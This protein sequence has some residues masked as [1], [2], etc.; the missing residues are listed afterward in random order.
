MARA[1]APV[2]RR[3]VL[4]AVAGACLLDGGAWAV[5]AGRGDGHTGSAAT[6]TAADPRAVSRAVTTG[7][8]LAITFDDGPDP[9]V[10]PAILDVLAAYDVRATFFMIGRNVRAHPDLARR[11]VAA[12]HAVANHTQ[13]HLWLDGL[14]AA[15]IRDQVVLG[16]RSLR[17][18]VGGPGPLFRPPRGWTSPDVAAVTE[19]LQVRSVF[20]SDCLE[21]HLSAGYA[22]AAR[23]VVDGAEPGSIILCHD[24]GRLDGP[25][26]QRQDRSRTVAALP[27]MLA[28]ILA[29]GLTPALLSD[30]L[31]TG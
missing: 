1:S 21:A 13:D 20:W 4:T 15:G 12:G 31:R 26:P 19:E 8:H 14:P 29:K 7:P 5:A 10:T 17:D 22:A 30:L 24:G 11:V 3:T 25:N 27:A 18:V 28:G 2:S 16:A 6:R 23:A 9:D